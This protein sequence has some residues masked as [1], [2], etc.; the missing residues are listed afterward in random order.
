LR[1]TQ[2][3]EFLSVSIILMSSLL[4]AEKHGGSPLH[5]SPG[6]PRQRTTLQYKACHD[7]SVES[8]HKAELDINLLKTEEYIELPVGDDLQFRISRR[9]ENS[10]V[11]KNGD[12]EA[13]FTWTG[14]HIAGSVHAGGVSW[15][16]E[17][18][19]DDCFLWI[20]QK[21]D[22]QDE[23]TADN[24]RYENRISDQR[25]I[26]TELQDKGLEDTTTVVTYTIMIW[27]TPQFYDSFESEADMNVFIDLIFEETN[28][29]YINSKIPIRV[30]KL[31]VKPHPTLVD[32]SNPDQLVDDFEA[33]M[34]SSEL[35]NCADA[36]ALL[37]HDFDSCGIA[38]NIGTFSSCRS[39]S[40]TKKSCATGYYSFGHELAH[41]FGALHNIERGGYYGGDAYGYLI[42]PRGD[43][44]YSGYRT[45][46]GYSYCGHENR[47][48]YYS[49]PDVIFPKTGTPTGVKDKSNNARVIS[50]NRFVIAACGT[51]EPNGS[52]N[53]EVPTPGCG[54]KNVDCQVGNGA[55]YRGAATKTVTG[56]ECTSLR[57]F[58]GLGYHNNC[59]NP[60]GE[61]GVWC[62]T[63]NPN[64]YWELCDVKE[65]S[66]CD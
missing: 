20:K 33:S 23:L 46:L 25:Q 28:Q 13:I 26:R 22:W 52:C 30:S 42:Q 27:Y 45:I 47:V 49:N 66:D 34:P 31:G 35:L 36:A 9:G 64:K 3:L 63:S 38:N 16:L 5:I 10:A 29:G 18:C 1:M 53:G 50:A 41:N 24:P 44:C 19:G 15:V 12:A 14:S 51:D 37:I 54:T 17:G 65:C 39:F 2:L 56:F 48:N 60:D 59:R 4:R 62:F 61:P 6:H 58:Y 7:K 43:F 11:F 21:N 57:N 32:I 40:V 55:E 8:C